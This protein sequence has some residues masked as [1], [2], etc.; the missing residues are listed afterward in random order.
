VRIDLNADLGELP[1][2]EGAALDEAVLRAVTS[3]SVACGGHAGDGE[4][5]GRT[6][7]AARAAGV[8]AGAHPSYPDREGF[9]RRRVEMPLP[10]LREAVEGQ[11]EALTAAARTEGVALRHL[12]PHGALYNEAHADEG[13]AEMLAEVCAA[14]SLALYGPPGGALARA[15]GAAGVAFVPEGFADRRYLPDGRLTPRGRPGAVIDDEGAQAR[16]ALS[17]ARGEP[18]EAEGGRLSLRVRTICLHGDT[19]GAAASAKALRTAL[20]AAGV[21]VAAPDAG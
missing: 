18:V 20:E 8:A 17:L 5:M 7:R 13:L 4:A 14:R 11:V 3:C 16:Q 12:K 15:A 6:L 19:P 21:T 2:A 1:G 9:G 10:A